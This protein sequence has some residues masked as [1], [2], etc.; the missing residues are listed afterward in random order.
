M[1]ISS[2]EVLLRSM[3]GVVPTRQREQQN[4]FQLPQQPQSN[5]PPLWMR[6]LKTTV[7]QL[8]HEGRL[9]TPAPP[10]Q[11]Q[12]EF[13]KELKKMVPRESDEDEGA[14]P[15]WK[16]KI[17]ERLEKLR[18]LGI[19]PTLPKWKQ[20]L[21]LQQRGE[22]VS[23]IDFMTDD[24][25]FGE[26]NYSAAN[27]EL[28]RKLQQVNAKKGGNILEA[29]QGLG[30]EA[31]AQM[32][33]LLYETLQA[34]NATNNDKQQ[35]QQ[36]Q[37]QQSANQY[38]NRYEE[39]YDSDEERGGEA[40]ASVMSMQLANLSAKAKPS[41][42]IDA[43]EA[44]LS[45]S[46]AGK[47]EFLRKFRKMGFHTK[48]QFVLE[49]Q[50]QGQTREEKLPHS[51]NYVPSESNEKVDPGGLKPVELRGEKQAAPASTSKISVDLKP[52]N[53]R[54]QREAIDR[55]R[56]NLPAPS[57]PPPVQTK[58]PGKTAGSLPEAPSWANDI[59]DRSVEE[60]IKSEAIEQQLLLDELEEK[61]L[62]PFIL[63]FRQIL[64]GKLDAMTRKAMEAMLLEA[65]EAE[66]LTKQAVLAAVQEAALST[67]IP[68]AQTAMLTAAVGTPLIERG[69]PPK[70]TPA[71]K[72]V[73]SPPRASAKPTSS[74]ASQSP[75][76]MNKSTA[77]EAGK[78][79]F[80]KKFGKMN[81]NKSESVTEANGSKLAPNDDR[82]LG[83]DQTSRFDTSPVKKWQPPNKKD[84]PQVNKLSATAG[85]AKLVNHD[86]AQ[87]S[88]ARQIK[89]PK[90]KLEA[91]MVLAKVS[92]A[93][94][95]D[96]TGNVGD[97]ANSAPVT[98]K[99]PEWMQKF[100]QMKIKKDQP[101]VKTGREVAT[102]VETTP[103]NLTEEQKAPVVAPRAPS[104]PAT[105]HSLAKGTAALIE[106]SSAKP[107]WLTKFG[108]MKFNKDEDVV[109]GESSALE[110]NE[111]HVP[112]HVQ[113]TMSNVAGRDK[114]PDS[115]V[116]LKRLQKEVEEEQAKIRDCGSI[117]NENNL[118][119]K[120]LEVNSDANM[121]TGFAFTDAKYT[122]GV[123]SD[124]SIELVADTPGTEEELRKKKKK[125]KATSSSDLSSVGLVQEVAVVVLQGGGANAPKATENSQKD[126]SELKREVDKR[127][128]FPI[129][130]KGKDSRPD[131]AAD[132]F[133]G[134]KSSEKFD[135]FPVATV[136]APL[137]G[138]GLPPDAFDA[139]GDGTKMFEENAKFG[140]E[141]RASQNFTLFES[142]GLQP[143]TDRSDRRSD[144][145]SNIVENATLGSKEI[146][147]EGFSGGLGF[148]PMAR[149]NVNLSKKF[150]AESE[151][152]DSFEVFD[153]KA[154][155]DKPI[156]VS[157]YSDDGDSAIV[158]MEGEETKSIAPIELTDEQAR[159]LWSNDDDEKSR[160]SHRSSSG[161]RR[162]H[163]TNSGNTRGSS[164]GESHRDAHGEG[165]HRRKPSRSATDNQDAKK[166]HTRRPSTDPRAPEREHS[167]GVNRSPPKISD[168]E[169][170]SIVKEKSSRRF[171]MDEKVA[172]S[173][174]PSTG[175][176]Q[177]SVSPNRDRRSR[178]HSLDDCS[179]MSKSSAEESGSR[180]SKY[181]S[182]R[183]SEGMGMHSNDQD[184][185]SNNRKSDSSQSK[186][187]KDKPSSSLDKDK[188]SSKQ[189]ERSP[190]KMSRDRSPKP[191]LESREDPSKSVLKSK[192]KSMS[193][194][195]LSLNSK[196]TTALAAKK[197][198]ASGNFMGFL[199]Q[200]VNGLA[201]QST[202]S[203]DTPTGSCTTDSMISPKSLGTKSTG[204]ASKTR[205]S[206]SGKKSQS[207]FGY[208][209]PAM[210]LPMDFT[211]FDGHTSR[212]DDPYAD[213][214]NFSDPFLRSDQEK[215][216]GLG[217]HFGSDLGGD[218]F[219]EF[220]F[221]ED[222]I[223]EVPPWNGHSSNR[224][225]PLDID[226][227]ENDDFSFVG[228]PKND[229]PAALPPGGDRYEIVNGKLTRIEQPSPSGRSRP[230]DSQLVSTVETRKKKKAGKS[231]ADSMK[232]MSTD[233]NDGD[234]KLPFSRTKSSD[235]LMVPVTTP[236]IKK[237]KSSAALVDK[238]KSSSSKRRG[239]KT[240]LDTYDW[241]LDM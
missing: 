21:L 17:Q 217:D 27:P 144:I 166:K 194:V 193:S 160:R 219:D 75:Q 99:T 147:D 47:P 146:V 10:Q 36:Q 231:N 105:K 64:A 179:N 184:A 185:P 77:D 123:N 80:M 125:K 152:R 70:A 169:K 63:K 172:L 240:T 6:E 192:K 183:S 225:A 170:R 203:M 109:V 157:R 74:Y 129:T 180:R 199:Q 204:N 89:Q 96:D 121:A 103:I 104:L 154:Q 59:F 12:P 181:Q 94:F 71:P 176:S 92:S 65:L 69:V 54:A 24:D 220:E 224:S 43:D 22:S 42:P 232:G 173:Q 108:Q 142:F 151:G 55:Q 66:R 205:A 128:T 187:E 48:Q 51:V 161:R 83:L 202:I 52:M 26:S 18:R 16:Q 133:L 241:S 4:V 44:S 239:S 124:E 49:A 223:A 140:N 212:R 106:D 107:E 114:E 226:S 41:R 149:D 76:S 238:K 143:E 234:F 227:F 218:N 141:E 208:P 150:E 87:P 56:Y 127:N 46:L 236:T 139:F 13:F 33:Q 158:S 60:A 229:R 134:S 91:D 207:D 136:S 165:S 23:E 116:F 3:R 5:E 163:Q 145:T 98:D 50:G 57:K 156:S 32:Q 81:F 135:A 164:Q 102:E 167:R 228:G 159:F 162:A 40:P 110:K 38:D 34:E 118:T 126:L 211:D 198:S 168:N 95:D 78:P 237:Q 72:A 101:M 178:R 215:K 197:A 9:Y 221:E 1:D 182:R 148:A 67:A 122:T 186:R 62:P 85:E 216:K 73:W 39:G 53:D 131:N 79:E 138:D 235:R 30:L 115:A 19:D 190:K 196:K 113:P 213:D 230:S 2:E 100:N 111:R 84:P 7:K 175:D 68:S 86:E 214:T 82:G 14:T 210:S 15:Q 201:L 206:K 191:S 93:V 88:E 58:R 25:M 195:D 222:H 130:S 189:D 28:L 155:G 37:Q 119:K 117:G 174:K 188:S 29:C 112:Q 153:Q 35:Y 177:R 171:S 233:K 209:L 45:E 61:D 132:D 31:Q 200:S 8:K 120:G 137:D 11:A 20:K 97:D 90:S